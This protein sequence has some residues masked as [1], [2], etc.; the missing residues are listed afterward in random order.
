M[1]T[2]ITCHCIDFEANQQYMQRR[3]NYAVTVDCDASQFEVSTIPYFM[4][5]QCR[6]GEP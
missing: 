2:K 3:S 6:W 5:C 1:E 4:C